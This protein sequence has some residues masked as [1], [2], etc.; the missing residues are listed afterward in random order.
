MDGAK[1]LRRL[2]GNFL[3]KIQFNV[4]VFVSDGFYPQKGESVCVCVCGWVFLCKRKGK[5]EERI[6]RYIVLRNRGLEARERKGDF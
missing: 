6:C 3:G 5:S 2:H 1:D 4:C